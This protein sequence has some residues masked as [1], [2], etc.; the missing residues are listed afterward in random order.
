MGQAHAQAEEAIHVRGGQLGKLGSGGSGHA[1]VES[2]GAATS[3]SFVIPSRCAIERRT[4]QLLN[5]KDI[6]DDAFDV[7]GL[8]RAWVR[9]RDRNF[10]NMDAA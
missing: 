2:K 5:S 8:R 7:E 1:P 6:H 10:L 9:R 3:I 4:S